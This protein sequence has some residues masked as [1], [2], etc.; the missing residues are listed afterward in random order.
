MLVLSVILIWHDFLPG[1]LRV[2][3]HF[4][5]CWRIVLDFHSVRVAQT[6]RS[7]DLNSQTFSVILLLRIILKLLTNLS[8]VFFSLIEVTE[9]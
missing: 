4:I 2:T 1:N 5:L 7:L 3:K 9:A 6:L 8:A